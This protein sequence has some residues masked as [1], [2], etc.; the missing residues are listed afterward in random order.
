MKAKETS[1]QPD[2]VS[3]AVRTSSRNFA[4]AKLQHQTHPK[5]W[6]WRK[7]WRDSTVP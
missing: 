7:E 4:A 6:K 3:V 2:V 1:V 5:M